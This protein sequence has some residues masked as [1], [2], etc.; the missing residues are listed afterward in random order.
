MGRSPVH[1]D[2]EAAVQRMKAPRKCGTK[3]AGMMADY[4]NDCRE[5]AVEVDKLHE[6]IESTLLRVKEEGESE[7][8]D[9]GGEEAVNKPKE[10]REPS[11]H[12]NG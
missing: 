11:E 4:R 7:D 5:I 8:V 6:L 2:F 12:E 10:R 1:Y 9:M 3:M